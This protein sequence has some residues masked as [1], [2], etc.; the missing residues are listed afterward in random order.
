ML[1]S[2]TLFGIKCFQCICITFK[3]HIS[4]S[5]YITVRG[6]GQRLWTAHHLIGNDKVISSDYLTCDLTGQW[7]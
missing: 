5:L 3:T 7:L 2:N 4:E 6:K 1:T